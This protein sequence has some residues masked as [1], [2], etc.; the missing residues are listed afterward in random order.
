MIEFKPKRDWA[1]R[2]L[3]GES[4]DVVAGGVNR[5]AWITA[6][7]QRPDPDPAT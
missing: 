4:M 1:A 6:R 5:D 7:I 2:L 3:V